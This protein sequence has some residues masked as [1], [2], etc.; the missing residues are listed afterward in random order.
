MPFCELGISAQDKFAKK[1]EETLLRKKKEN[2][3]T[4]FFKIVRDSLLLNNT[5]LDRIHHCQHLKEG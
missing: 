2:G 5:N 4:I 3:S 1:S